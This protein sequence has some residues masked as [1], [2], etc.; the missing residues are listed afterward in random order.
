MSILDDLKA[1]VIASNAASE[2]SNFLG[3]SDNDKTGKTRPV[4]EG[5]PDT[6]RDKLLAPENEEMLYALQVV[7]QENN[8]LF[9]EK[10]VKAMAES[11]VFGFVI[12]EGAETAP[13]EVKAP[14]EIR[15]VYIINETG[16][17]VYFGPSAITAP[18]ASGHA[19]F[20]AQSFGYVKTGKG[21][22]MPVTFGKSLYVRIADVVT[23]SNTVFAVGYVF[24][25]PQSIL[26]YDV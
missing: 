6:I 9:A 2:A 15:S 12:K 4:V 14:F 13:Q 19:S 7:A 18:P 23:Y 3:M 17:T 10:I 25:K 8:R 22:A 24:S 16:Q 21:K 26:E 1:R 5:V 11:E 20:L